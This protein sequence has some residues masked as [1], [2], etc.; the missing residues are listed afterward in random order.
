MSFNVW[1]ESPRSITEIIEDLEFENKQLKA[2][3]RDKDRQLE[4]LTIKT[5]DDW[6][7]WTPYSDHES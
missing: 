2:V 4:Q 3:I 6:Q 7:R 5:V 1:N